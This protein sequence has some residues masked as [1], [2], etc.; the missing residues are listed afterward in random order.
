MGE[1]GIRSTSADSVSVGKCYLKSGENGFHPSTILYTTAFTIPAILIILSYGRIWF[2]M[3]QNNKM[4]KSHGSKYEIFMFKHWSIWK[5]CD[6]FRHVT[7]ILEKNEFKITWT[8]FLISLC[9]FL[10]V[11]P[12]LITSNLDA[13]GLYHHVDWLSPILY[14]LYWTHY[15]INFFIYAAVNEKFRLAYLYF[16]KEVKMLVFILKLI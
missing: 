2:Y 5:L 9:Y 16:L 12:R 15:A 8:L 14:C 1:F 7:K 11:M 4:I 3:W 6:T 13:L 10:M